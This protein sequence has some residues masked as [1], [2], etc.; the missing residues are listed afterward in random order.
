MADLVINFLMQQFWSYIGMAVTVTVCGYAILAGSWRARF[1]GAVYLAAYIIPWVFAA[2]SAHRNG[3]FQ[4][5]LAD[6][7]TLPGFITVNQKSPYAWTR[8][9]LVLQMVSIAADITNLAL[10]GRTHP[11]FVILDAVLAYG[12]MASLLTGTIAAQVRWRRE[13][14]QGPD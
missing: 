4:L 5:F 1:G 13:R 8:W 7:L 14:D 3:I 11:A 9:A 12:V 2:T 6:I 10:G